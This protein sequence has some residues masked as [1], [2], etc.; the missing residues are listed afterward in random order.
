MAQFLQNDLE[1]LSKLSIIGCKVQNTIH[2][3]EALGKLYIHTSVL[4]ETIKKLQT[5]GYCS[6]L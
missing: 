6:Q 1:L 4:R 3:K 2:L 5:C